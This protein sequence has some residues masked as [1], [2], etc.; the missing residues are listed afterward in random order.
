MRSPI[1]VSTSTRP[2]GVSISKQLSAW[3]SVLSGLSSASTSRCHIVR[4]TGPKAAPAS[5]VNVPAWIRATRTPP[6]SSL[7]QSTLS[8]STC[9]SALWAAF[10]DLPPLRL[11][12]F[13]ELRRCRGRLALVLG[14]RLARSI[15]PLD[16]A[17][18]LGEGDLA[19][20]HSAVQGY[21][22]VG[23][24]GQLEGQVALPAR[25]HV[26]RGRVDQ[27]SQSAKRAASLQPRDDIVGQ[28]DPF[29]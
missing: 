23:H 15:G 9:G 25:V 28:L 21:R 24:I 11:E 2:A 3:L 20:L 29:E 13:V 17:G 26:A 6:P 10:G 27:Q 18:H 1:P 7:R 19:D 5:V 4:G 8:F 14:T 16:R 12:V 22:K